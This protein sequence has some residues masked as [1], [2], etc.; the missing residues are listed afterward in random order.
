MKIRTYSTIYGA[1]P[2]NEMDQIAYYLD[3]V[4]AFLIS[5]AKSQ[6]FPSLAKAIEDILINIV[7]DTDIL[8]QGRFDDCKSVAAQITAILK[9]NKQ[10]YTLSYGFEINKQ[11]QKWV[12]TTFSYNIQFCQYD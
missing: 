4:H 10:T 8:K 6:L 9:Q 1:K 2:N 5:D 12:L 11:G 3:C 7:K